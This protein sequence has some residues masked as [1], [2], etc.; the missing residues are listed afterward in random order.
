MET[1]ID[2]QK[3]ESSPSGGV[4]IEVDVHVD[5]LFDECWFY[6][7]LLVNRRARMPR[8]Y[9]DP[10]SSSNFN[11]EISKNSHTA[12]SQSTNGGLV[13]APSLP[14]YIGRKDE[15][16][17]RGKL[18]RQL[19]DRILPQQ[20][21]KP[22]GIQKENETRRIKP[23]AATHSSLQRTQTLPSYI[24]RDQDKDSDAL[25][26]TLILE[27][28]ASSSKTSPQRLTPKSPSSSRH[29][30]PRNPD[31]ESISNK[32]DMK[33]TRKES[34]NQKK[35]RKSLSY[36]EVEEL[37]GF[38]EL[39]FRFDKRREDDP[40]E[41]GYK[42]VM[43]MRSR[44]YNWSQSWMERSCAPLIPTWVAKNSAEDMKAHIKFWARTVATNVRQEC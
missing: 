37:R 28:L 8:C 31:A 35:L 5:D 39:G 29:R 6:G 40:N 3:L 27:A 21:T 26:S 33:E 13:R 42:M 17:Q 16:Q 44:P 11:Q 36:L 15:V 10:C 24:G 1:T 23:A 7:N 38:E 43:M 4:D 25:M 9:S 14:P 41:L 32:H 30:P 34:L 19:S 22:E 18:G 12:N 2:I 20:P